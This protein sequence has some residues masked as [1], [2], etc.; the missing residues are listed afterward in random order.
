MVA[1]AFDTPDSMISAVM[2][3]ALEGRVDIHI[4]TPVI[5]FT[6]LGAVTP[7]LVIPA[8]VSVAAVAVIV[9]DPSMVS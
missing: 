3:P 4:H 8:R 1:V 7:E 2:L 6:R 9:A 5:L